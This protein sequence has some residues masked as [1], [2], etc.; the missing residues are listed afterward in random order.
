MRLEDL[1][2]ELRRLPPAER[3]ALLAEFRD[4][5]GAEV[6]PR[7]F[8]SYSRTDAA[9]VADL[10]SGLERDG[11]KVWFDV[12][13]P[14]IGEDYLAATES[15]IRESDYCV[16]VVSVHSM[17]S[18]EV[19][20]EVEIASRLGKPVL[21]VLQQDATLMTSRSVLFGITVFSGVFSFLLPA[22]LRAQVWGW[23]LLPAAPITAVLLVAE[24]SAAFRRW[25]PTRP[26]RRNFLPGWLRRR[27]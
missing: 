6:A 9:F 23:F 17:A 1:S 13:E 7:V 8:L 10:M 26:E 12:R 21:P 27:R 24:R 3:A 14:A 19:A 16:V 2:A 15:G 4:E 5:F 20:R 22:N 11:V 25:L 18:V